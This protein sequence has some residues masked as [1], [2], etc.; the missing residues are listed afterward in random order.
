MTL[1]E[2]SFV[3]PLLAIG[4]GLLSFASPCCLPLLPAYLGIIA[5]SVGTHRT[6]VGGWGL[7]WNGLAFVAGLSVVFA[8]L[9]ASASAL[10]SLLLEQRLLLEQAGGVVIVVLGLQ[11][12]GLLRLGWLARTYL[13]MDP[14]RAA[15]RGGMLGAFVVGAAFSIGWTP[16]I[17]LFLASLLT[18]AAQQQTVAEGTLLLLCY[19][20]GLG[21]PFMV[22]GLAADRAL[23][24][25]RALRT[26]LGAIERAGGVVL[27]G[28]GVLLF[29]GQLTLINIWAI[30][31]FGLGLAL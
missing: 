3:T 22:A 23:R 5:G 24:W 14:Q 10:G 30:R 20:L 21:I 25:S 31:T 19:G 16:C 18:L 9:G 7:L 27:V 15:S 28:M 12:L 11:M 13:R 6:T 17:G 29:T 26:Q 2:I 4:F 1:N 8:I